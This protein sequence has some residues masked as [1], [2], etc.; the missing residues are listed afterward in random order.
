MRLRLAA[1]CLALPLAACSIPQAPQP[2]ATSEP[3]V[4]TGTW[5]AQDI[6]GRGVIDDAQSTV[7]FEAGNQIDGATGCNRY[8]G[9]TTVEGENLAFGPLGTTRMACAPA[10]MDQERKFLDALAATRSYRFEGP[11]L[12][13]QDASGTALVRLIRLE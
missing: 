11:Y 3:P 9:R 12:F 13:L 8:F 2:A 5:V 7:S 6:A 1:V 4:L 10:V